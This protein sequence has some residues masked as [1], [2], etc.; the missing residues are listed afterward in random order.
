MA[1]A[2]LLNSRDNTTNDVSIVKNDSA[3]KL[4]TRAKDQKYGEPPDGGTRAILVMMSAFLCNSILFGII[5]TWGTIYIKLQQQLETHGDPEASSKAS[6]VGS[7]TVGTTFLLSPVSSILTDK[8]GLR[9]TTLIGGLL[10]SCGMFLSSFVYHNVEALYVTYGVMFG[11]GA[12][13]AYTPTLAILGHY[14]KRY[15]GVVS[16]F[17]TSGSSVFTAILP[18]LLQWLL[19]KGLSITFCVQAVMSI[20]VVACALIY[21]PLQAPPPPPKRKPGESDRNAMLRSLIN[22]DIWKKK[23]YIIWAFSIP[24]ALIGYFVPYTH[25]PKF[26]SIIYPNENENFPIM[27]IG[28]TSGIGRI[29]FGFIA[30]LKGVNRIYLQQ[31]SFVLMGLLTMLMPVV[32]SFGQLLGI[33]LMMGVV[34]GCFIS[35]L[36][37][38]AFDICGPRGATQAIGF[39]LGLCSIPL[40]VGP[41]IAGLLYDQTKS[42]TL[43]FFLAGIP[44]ICGAVIMCLIGFVKDEPDNVEDENDNQLE[45]ALAKPAWIEDGKVHVNG[46]GVGNNSLN[47]KASLASTESLNERT[48]ENI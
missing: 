41:P 23:R 26:V 8:I 46:G 14:F 3:N 36:G 11:F 2:N 31:I 19:T 48:T 29:V 44:P 43:A 32:K 35:L 28:I 6:L 39:L 40:T 13:L 17:V 7:L 47:R 34:D 20:F 5:N 15:L 16:G 22:V 37:P 25:V 42:Y 12:A 21:K 30:D 38:I 45:I 10:A 4:S 1:D 27:C 24:V 33:A 9:K 18:F